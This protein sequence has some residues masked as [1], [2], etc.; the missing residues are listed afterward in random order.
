MPIFLRYRAPFGEIGRTCSEV[1]RFRNLPGYWDFPARGL[2]DLEFTR[3][4]DVL[5][6]ADIARGSETKNFGRILKSELPLNIY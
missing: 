2:F 3:V 1:A 4:V 5:D 6:G